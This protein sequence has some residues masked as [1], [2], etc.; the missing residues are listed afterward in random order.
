MFLASHGNE[1]KK[2]QE[3]RRM[4]IGQKKKKTIVSAVED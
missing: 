2:T 3:E 1:R 4:Q